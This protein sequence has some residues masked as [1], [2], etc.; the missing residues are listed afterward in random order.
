MRSCDDAAV[1]P[2]RPR[3]ARPDSATAE[4]F[5]IK[6]VAEACGLPQ[7]VIAQLVPRTD[8]P[9]GFMY[10]A[11]QLRY[12]VEVGEDIRARRRSSPENPRLRHRPR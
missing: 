9:A 3:Q 6:D 8:T 5:T 10:T 7:P 4:M 11:G 12:A 1:V 2:L